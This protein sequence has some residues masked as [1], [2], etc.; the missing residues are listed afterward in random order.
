MVAMLALMVGVLGRK[1]LFNTGGSS[2]RLDS[3]N[4]Y[5]DS[6][7][8]VTEVR[9]KWKRPVESLP[10]HVDIPRLARKMSVYTSSPNNSKQPVL[11][12]AN[13]EINNDSQVMKELIRTLSKYLGEPQTQQDNI[14]NNFMEYFKRTADP[15]LA[16]AD[17]LNGVVGHESRT[18]GV[19]KAC[20]QSVLAPGVLVLSSLLSPTFRSSSLSISSPSLSLCVG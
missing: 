7:D 6:G 15:S 19:L 8:L 5:P 1:Y 14:D 2:S 16:L 3:S 18:A 10:V 13:N 17:F 4:S 9:D 20:N 12:A 11:S